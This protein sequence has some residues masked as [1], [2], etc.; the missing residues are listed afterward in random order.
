MTATV[1]RT[2]PG[3]GPAPAWSPRRLGHHRYRWWGLALVVCLLVAGVALGPEGFAGAADRTDRALTIMIVAFLGAGIALWGLIAS[4][5]SA[6]TGRVRDDVREY[7]EGQHVAMSHR[8]GRWDL[9]TDRRHDVTVTGRP[10]SQGPWR[11]AI[12]AGPTRWTVRARAQ[13]IV[14][15]DAGAR[16]VARAARRGPATAR[17]WEIGVEGYRLVVHVRG[18]RPAPR[19]TLLDE[20]GAA[21]LV[22]LRRGETPRAAEAR[23]PEELSPAAA[24]FVVWT[25]AQLEAN[26]RTAFD[27]DRSG[28]G[29]ASAADGTWTWDTSSESGSGDSGGGDGGGDGGGGG[30]D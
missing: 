6:V 30:G 8:D 27:R 10:D 14:A 29:S 22:R 19:R 25:V 21:W 13:E 23:L 3:G 26:L 28:T 24:A 1:E 2:P 18:R 20:S 16:E 9:R 7:A 11:G 15:R 4:L 5:I 17:T 12:E